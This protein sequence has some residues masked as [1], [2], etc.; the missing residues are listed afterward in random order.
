MHWCLFFGSYLKF[1]WI[2]DWLCP[3]C[4]PDCADACPPPLNGLGTWLLLPV[5]GRKPICACDEVCPAPIICFSFVCCPLL[6]WASF[7]LD[8][9]YLDHYF[10]HLP[11]HLFHWPLLLIDSSVASQ[12]FVQWTMYYQSFHLLQLELELVI[13]HRNLVTNLTHHL[14]G[15]IPI[16]VVNS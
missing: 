14:Y 3:E 7:D 13:F 2:W 9:F 10:E 15:P 1:P 12:T 16:S 5:S 11:N 4:T 6:E 8:I